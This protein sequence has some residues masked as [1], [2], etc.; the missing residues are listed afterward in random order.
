MQRKKKI[1]ASR[2]DKVR[3]K[4]YL[5]IIKQ[6]LLEDDVDHDITSR[7]LI[8]PFHRTGQARIV[9]R[10]NGILAGGFIA[11]EVFLLIDFLF[12]TNQLIEEGSAFKKGDTILELKGRLSTILSGERVA[13][14]LLSFMSGIATQ[15]ARVKKE[16]ANIGNG[17]IRILDTRKTIPGMRLLSK[18]AITMGGGYNHRLNLSEMGLIKDNHIEACGSILKAILSFVDKNPQKEY[19]A[20]V[21]SLQQLKKILLHAEECRLRNI[22]LDNMDNPTLSKAVKMI[23]ECE[24]TLGKKIYI[25]ASGGYRV[26]NLQNLKGADIDFVSMGSLTLETHPIDFSLEI[27]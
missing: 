14:N 10:E 5:P 18:Y 13:L 12:D 6:A 9:C 8:R 23:R 24:K 19:Q 25:E 2:F 4:K 21:E 17:K 7:A 11:Q 27:Y 3:K 1:Y 22:L 15:T 16:L 26:D 20:E